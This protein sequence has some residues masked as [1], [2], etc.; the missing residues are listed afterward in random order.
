MILQEGQV[1]HCQNPKCGAEILVRKDS[2]E[3]RSNPRCCCGAEMKKPYAT[4][5]LRRLEPTQELVDLF[6]SRE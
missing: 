5:K 4:P 2:I 6:K 3:G 1:Y